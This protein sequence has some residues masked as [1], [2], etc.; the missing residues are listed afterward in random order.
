MRFREGRLVHDFLYRTLERRAR[1]DARGRSTR[2]CSACAVRR[3][4]PANA[5]LRCACG[6][7]QDS[8][9]LAVREPLVPLCRIARAAERGV[10]DALDRVHARAS[11]PTSRCRET[12]D[13]PPLGYA[14]AQ[15][16]GI[17][18]LAENAHGLVLVDMH[19]AHERI[20]Y[21]KLKIAQDGEG[22]RS[23]LLL[24]PLTLAVSEREAAA[25]EEHAARFAELGFDIAR[26]GPAEHHRARIPVLLDGADVAAAR[27]R[28]RRR[29]RRARRYAPH[30]GKRRTNCLSTMACHGSVRAHRRLTLAG[31]E[32]AAARDGSDRTFRPVQSRPADLGAVAAWP[33]SIAFS[34]AGAERRAHRTRCRF[35]EGNSMLKLALRLLAASDRRS[36]VMSAEVEDVDNRPVSYESQ[37]QTWRT[38]RVERLKAP[39]GWLSLIGLDWLKEGKNTVGSGQEQRHRA[40]RR[41]RRIS[42]S[43]RSQGQG[44]DRARSLNRG[45][46]ID[47][48]TQARAPAARRFAREA[49]HGRVRHARASTS[50]IATAR[51]ALRV[52]DTE[53][54][55]RKNFVGIDYFPI[56][57]KWRVEA[58]WVPF[59]PPHTLEIPNVL[60]QIDKM[61]VPGKAVFERDGKNYELAAGARRCRAK[62]LWFIFADKTSAKETYGG[63]ALPLHRH[64]EGRQG[65]HRFQQGLQ[66]AVRVHAARDVSAGAAGESPDFR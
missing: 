58:K 4:V 34:C 32:R 17:F 49:D 24:V 22:I 2:A 18:V 6:A 13:S 9:G 53:A 41:R 31:N 3:S 47:G 43:S 29:S 20:T 50:S 19:A 25:V 33:S 51:K 39:N 37:I 65:R 40:R 60:G 1:A 26:S 45:A 11:R 62:E 64:A 8:L 61:P 66:P 14:L 35:H 30:R 48:K 21:E 5:P 42:A 16:H 54:Q 57:P 59:N 27:A 55:T 28:C 7:A 12:G 44:D 10:A 52:K 23:Q 46:T 36:Q 63:G 38:Q 56:D 15:L